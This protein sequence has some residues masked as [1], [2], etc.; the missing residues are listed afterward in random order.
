MKPTNV[1]Y[2]SILGY[3]EVTGF[4]PVWYLSVATSREQNRLYSES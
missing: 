1:L 2:F 3:Q 4:K